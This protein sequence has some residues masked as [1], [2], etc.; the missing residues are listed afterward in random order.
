VISPAFSCI[1]TAA[2]SGVRF[3]PENKKQ[4]FLL[5]GKPIIQHTIDIFYHIENIDEIVITLPKHDLEKT[6]EFLSTIY[7]AKIKCIVGGATRQASIYEALLSCKN[8]DFVMIHDAVRPFFDKKDLA[9]MMDMVQKNL[10]IVPGTMINNTIK[11]ID[12]T[13]VETTVPRD[14]LIAVYTPQI[15]SMPLILDLH[16]RA[17]DLPQSFTDDASICEHFGYRVY[18]YETSSPSLKITTKDDLL[19]AKFIIDNLIE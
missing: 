11:K 9:Q 17:K 10:A 18:W 3:D 15:F 16:Q 1:I 5:D 4:F 6:A 8:N 13:H 12:G 7:T 2:G 14:N 19:L